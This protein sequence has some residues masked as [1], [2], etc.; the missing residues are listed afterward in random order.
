MTGTIKYLLFVLTICSCTLTSFGQQSEIDSLSYLLKTAKQDTFKIRLR[1][2]IGE[3]IPVLRITYWDSIR[4][5]A[6]KWNLKKFIAE[7]I[8]NIGVIYDNHGEISKALE[9]Y[10][11]GLKI[12]EEIGDKHGIAESL[13]NIGFVFEKHGDIPHALE[14]DHKGLKIQ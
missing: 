11:E 4:V 3:E 14:Y 10:N 13:N 12:R 5:D 8:N 2:E 6:E 1:A 9:Y 7:A